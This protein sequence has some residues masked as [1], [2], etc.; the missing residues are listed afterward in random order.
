[1]FN[2]VLGLVAQELPPFDFKIFF[3]LALILI[4]TKFLGILMRKLGLPQ[5]VGAIVAGL[6][7]GPFALGKHAIVVETEGIRVLA[8]IGVVMIMFSAGLDTNL[9]EIKQNGVASVI[10]TMLGVLVPLGLGYVVAGM[11]Y[12]FGPELTL[13]KMFIGVILTAT[14]VGI[15]VEVLK[16]MG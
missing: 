3:D 5:V 9:K 6:L 14:S 15:T 1:M 12:G 16:E 7:L 13:E 10:I 2:N 4:S 8:Q 11:I